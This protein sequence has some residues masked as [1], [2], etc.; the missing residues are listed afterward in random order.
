MT[1]EQCF[2]ALLYNYTLE[3]SK[4]LKITDPWNSPQ[5]K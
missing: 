4:I 5:F 3:L 1:L 2:Q